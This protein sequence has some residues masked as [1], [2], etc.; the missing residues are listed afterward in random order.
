MLFVLDLDVGA[1]SK[2]KRKV[3]VKKKEMDG[4]KS[5]IK[6]DENNATQSYNIKDK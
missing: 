1:T 4:M 2:S 5:R 3:G 6:I